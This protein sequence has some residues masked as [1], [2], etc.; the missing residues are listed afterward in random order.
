MILFTAALVS[1]ALLFISDIADK[2]YG[3][4]G[5]LAPTL[6]ILGSLGIIVS[7]SRLLF[8]SSFM[9]ALHISPGAILFFLIFLSLLLYTLFPALTHGDTSTVER[10]KLPLVSTGVYA[11]C[12]HPGVLWMAGCCICL[13]IICP[14]AEMGILAFLVAF[15]D[16]VYVWWQD[17]FIFPYTISHYNDYKNSV[18]FLIP[19]ALSVVR[20]LNNLRQG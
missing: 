15:F 1:Y 4:K 18:P 16:L 12:R 3:R 11:L 17:L 9:G 20:C 13:Y 8:S 6:F 2:K 19:T 14:T 5:L 10:G 7:F